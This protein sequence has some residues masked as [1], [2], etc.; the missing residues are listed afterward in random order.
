MRR[1]AAQTS[2]V[3]ANIGNIRVKPMNVWPMLILLV[4]VVLLVM[5]L[6]RVG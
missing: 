5:W 1:S 4:V 2:A 3:G 6:G